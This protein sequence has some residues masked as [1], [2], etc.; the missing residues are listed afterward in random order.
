M[1][2]GTQN[3]CSVTTWKDEVGKEAGGMFRWKS[4]TYAYGRFMLIYDRVH[5]NV[6]K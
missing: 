3:Q 1:N 6:V 4:H 2:Q 5:H